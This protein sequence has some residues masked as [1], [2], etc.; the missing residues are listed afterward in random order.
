MFVT[1]LVLG[2]DSSPHLGAAWQLQDHGGVPLLGAA[3]D[4]ARACGFDQLVV[5][6][7]SAAAQIRECVDF[8]RV[9]V[10][11][12][13]HADTG[14][15]S[16]V[17][18]LDAVDRRA[19]GLVVLAGDQP[20]V[21][22]ATV[23]SLVAESA[24]L[25]GVCRYEDGESYPCWFSRELFGELRRLRTDA[26]LWDLI[27]SGTHRVTKVDAIG[28]IPAR[29]A[30]WSTYHQPL[31]TSAVPQELPPDHPLPLPNHPRPRRRTPN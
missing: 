30:T 23:W 20:G 8:S 29:A 1:G 17:P 15:A 27:R 4:S 19:D 21:T 5:T 24:T 13:P 31:G 16:I 2:A 3:V 12:S 6:L 7:G 26:D 14:S 25:I 22:S 10:V 18:A 28:N 11:E 9:R